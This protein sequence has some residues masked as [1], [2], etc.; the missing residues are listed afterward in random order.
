MYIFRTFILL[1][2]LLS[3]SQS[4]L[5]KVCLLIL[6]LLSSASSQVGS[7]SFL[8]HRHHHRPVLHL[9]CILPYFYKASLFLLYH[10]SGQLPFWAAEREMS[11][12]TDTPGGSLIPG[13]KR[14]KETFGGLTNCGDT[15]STSNK[16]RF[17]REG[18]SSRSSCYF[19]IN[20][21]LF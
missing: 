17:L 13:M 19:E 12:L 4:F 3:Q 21:M 11:T 1:L 20:K 9:V 6:K 5:K 2:R 16:F 18:F 8:P 14:A 15:Y 10:S 7:F